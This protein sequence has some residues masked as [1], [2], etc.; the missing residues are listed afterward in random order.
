CSLG[1]MQCDITTHKPV[2]V[3]ATD[4]DVDPTT[5]ERV[6]VCDGVDDDCDGVTD[7]TVVDTATGTPAACT[8]NQDCPTG[9]SCLTGRNGLACVLAKTCATN[10]DCASV[11]G[12]ICM[13]GVTAKVCAKPAAGVGDPCDVPTTAPACINA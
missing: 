4:P 5:K 9:A 8:R 12:T 10:A 2:C 11:A 1:V 6:D 13:Q 7:G 3:G